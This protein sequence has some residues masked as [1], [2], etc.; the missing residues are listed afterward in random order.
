MG[1]WVIFRAAWS[2][3]GFGANLPVPAPTV[4]SFRFRFGLLGAFHRSSLLRDFLVFFEGFSTLCFLI[5]G[6]FTCSMKK[7]FF[8]CSRDDIKI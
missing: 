8:H 2:E 1:G 6:T 4:P 3:W 7:N 5:F